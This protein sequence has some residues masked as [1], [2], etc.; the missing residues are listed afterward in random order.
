[1][2]IPRLFTRRRSKASPKRLGL[3]SDPELSKKPDQKGSVDHEN[4]SSGDSSSASFFVTFSGL[5]LWLGS[6]NLPS[7]Y[8]LAPGHKLVNVWAEYSL[9]TEALVT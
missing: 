8:R 7:I 9:F 6:I 4:A 3:T 5:G 1:M 2:A